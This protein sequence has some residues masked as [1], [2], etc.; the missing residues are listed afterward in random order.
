LK[1]KFLVITL[2]LVILAWTVSL[3]LKFMD[4]PVFQAMRNIAEEIVSPNKASAK[5]TIP[6]L[7]INEWK[8]LAAGSRY[9]TRV[10]SDQIQI[11]TTRRKQDL[12]LDE[13]SWESM[14][15]KG[16]NLGAALPGCF[17]S[18]F[19]AT[20]DQYYEWLEQMGDLGANVVRVYTILPPEFYEAMKRYNFN[21]SNQPV[22]LVQ[23]VWAY[24]LEE[25][26]YG[27]SSYIEDF[28]SEIRDVINVIHGNAVINARPGHAHG[29]YNA[30]VSQHT[31]S[32]ILGREWE[33]NTVSDMKWQFPERN[34]YQG[35]FFS[36]P[37][38]QP[39]ECWIAETLDYAAK[40]ETSAYKFQHALS[41][42]NWLPLDP[43]YHDSEWI[44]WDEVRE[45]DNDLETIDP[46]KIHDS[47]LFKAG[48]FAS[49]HA[50]PYYP[51]FVYNDPK[52]RQAECSHGRCT[53]YGYLQDLVQ[54]HPGMPVVIA[55]FGVP[56]SRSASHF[57]PGGMNQGGHSE[58]EQ[59]RINAHLISDINES[60]A[61]GAILFA[62]IDEWFKHNWLLMDFELP[63]ERNKL[64]HNLEDPEQN[65]GVL[66]MESKNIVIDGN[67]EDWKDT[68]KI[69]A[70]P[71]GD[72]E[73]G[74]GDLTSLWATSDASCVYLR[75]DFDNAITGTDWKDH[76]IWIGID[77]HQKDKGDM[78][79]PGK[80]F[81]VPNGLEFVVEI[82]GPG[83][84]R[85][86]VDDPYDIY[87]DYF[88][89]EVPGYTSVSNS[90]G[91]YHEQ[92]L[93]TNRMRETLYGELFP[94]VYLTRS[95]LLWAT[96]N[97]EMPE[98]NSL[99]DIFQSEDGK[100]IEL[101]IPW[102]LLNVTDP[103]S[104]SVL[105][106]HQDTDELDIAV[107]PGF[108]FYLLAVK[109]PYDNPQLVDAMPDDFERGIKFSW[110]KWEVP[111][112][113]SRL[114]E[115]ASLVADAFR[116]IT[117]STN[118][119]EEFSSE[120]QAELS[121]WQDGKEEGVS[122]SF[123]DGSS[124][125]YRYGKKLLEKY[126]MYGTFFI[127][128]GWAGHSPL[129]T[130]EAEGLI[131]RRLSIPEIRELHRAGHE[132]G[133]HGHEH[134]SMN[135]MVTEHWI[136]S[137]FAESQTLISE[138]TGEQAVTVA[139]PYSSLTSAGVEILTD[140]GFRYGRISGNQ[141]NNPSDLVKTK[142]Y[143][144][145]IIDDQNPDPW[146]YVNTLDEN[147][148]KWT[149]L[150]YHHLFPKDAREYSQLADH[151][152][153]EKYNVT[154]RNFERQ[155]RLLRNR[156]LSVYPIRE[157]GDYL[158][159]Y[160]ATTLEFSEHQDSYVLTLRIDNE[161]NEDYPPLTVKL[162]TPWEW[163]SIEGSEHDGVYHNRTGY[164]NFD[165][166]PGSEIIIQRLSQEG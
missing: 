86:L 43:M 38:G 30:D 77:T 92:R 91:I 128:T 71:D 94:E 112:Y 155:V 109:S 90:N 65:F 82:A 108:M 21:N 144:H 55:E 53:Y 11:R 57:E 142:L 149:I 16:F 12:S 75:V 49:Y 106:N 116:A 42:V 136:K 66:A 118:P 62:W 143:S 87:T 22:Y 51:D 105:D 127:V 151:D 125:Q 88:K 93:L 119:A 101:R 115:G 4:R 164:I 153:E 124:Y 121:Q 72:I 165:A 141:S 160:K 107:T 76:A 17:P 100:H 44:E 18:E 48:Y 78:Y 132:I 41:F 26:S 74:I 147:R 163:I 33:P 19:K 52:Y 37:D 123:D 97:P 70:D 40:Y 46:G 68:D 61:A 102:A 29:V 150:Q 79:F 36:V 89:H 158:D 159:A 60:G 9:F 24:V 166:D 85:I 83:K 114:K 146:S 111:E 104:R 130:G 81:S 137:T 13:I 120:P 7:T 157:I 162:T 64:W 8:S 113:T 161:N 131:T 154:P 15:M 23:G 156:N 27:D 45:Y 6:N 1:G 54:A 20:K 122:I 50:Y 117:V 56:S 69:A 58:E 133:S 25:G 138:W 35:V 134:R 5:Q 28:H 32:I 129:I 2:L 99:A 145:V 39:M 3:M 103:S 126:G 139:Y 95:N 80:S 31:T 34:S 135:D 73:A 98:H 96:A 59:G 140:L 14:F 148:G 110:D 10:V 47:P 63:E 67:L 84:S 152:V